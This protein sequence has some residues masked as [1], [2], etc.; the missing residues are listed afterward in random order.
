MS[1]PSSRTAR[2]RSLADPW[3]VSQAESWP[4]RPVLCS[5]A[6][7]LCLPE[8]RPD[9]QQP[10][11]GGEPRQVGG[12]PAGE[13]A[14]LGGAAS[15]APPS[16][17]WPRGRGPG[18][19][20]QPSLSRPR[21]SEEAAPP[22][23]SFPPEGQELGGG[24]V[25]GHVPCLVLVRATRRDGSFSSGSRG[26]RPPPRPTRSPLSLASWQYPVWRP[27]PPSLAGAPGHGAQ[28]PLGAQC[29]RLRWQWTPRG[30]DLA[31]QVRSR[32]RGA[33]G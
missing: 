12:G 14:G 18:F 32:A 1:A 29:P 25:R 22:S 11:G 21:D 9:H 24:A 30:C 16:P 7:L 17:G 15:T 8:L 10:A 26:P 6:A 13:D 5:R 19:K 28:Q 2:P 33:Q 20:C 3:L 23:L 4:G 31:F 27:P